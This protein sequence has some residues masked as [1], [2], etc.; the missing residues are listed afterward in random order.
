MLKVFETGLEV[1][2]DQFFMVSVFNFVVLMF[3]V[4]VS[5]IESRWASLQEIRAFSN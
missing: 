2:R 3:L 1:A 4:L 5:R